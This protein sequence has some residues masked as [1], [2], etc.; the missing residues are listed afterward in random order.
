MFKR[1]F[2]FRPFQSCLLPQILE[3]NHSYE[4]VFSPMVHFHANQNY[5]HE[6]GF[7]R[8]LVLK[9]RHKVTR[10]WPIQQL[11][12]LELK[13]NTNLNSSNGYCNYTKDYE[14]VIDK[15]FKLW[16]TALRG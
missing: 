15:F 14:M 3:Q 11:A 7:S 6:K 12:S 1:L 5:F 16:Q 13:F 4:N 2:E 9:P 8:E 10:K